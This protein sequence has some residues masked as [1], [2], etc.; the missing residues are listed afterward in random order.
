MVKGVNKSVIEITDTGNKFFN[1]V[2]L[3]VSPEYSN[4][5]DKIIAGEAGEFIKKL[6][7]TSRESLRRAVMRERKRRRRIMLC[8]LG[9][10]FAAVGVILWLVL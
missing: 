5:S 10:F 9:A 1:K 2:I 8:A 6:Q 3:F 4:K 7:S